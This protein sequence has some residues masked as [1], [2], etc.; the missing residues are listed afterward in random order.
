MRATCGTGVGAVYRAIFDA[1][2]F[3][4]QIDLQNFREA[5]ESL[6]QGEAQ[7]IKD[8]VD[9]VKG[10]VDS[11]RYAAMGQGR[12]YKMRDGKGGPIGGPFSSTM[13]RVA[14]SC[15]E[16]ESTQML[17]NSSCQVL[18]YGDDIFFQGNYCLECAKAIV[19]A[20]YSHPFELERDST[21]VDE[22]GSSA[23]SPCV[24]VAWM[25][26]NTVEKADGGIEVK[27]AKRLDQRYRVPIYN[28]ADLQYA[29]SIFLA[30]LAR[31][32]T[33][34]DVERLREDFAM[35]GF[36]KGVLEN[37]YH[38]SRFKHSGAMM[39]PPHHAE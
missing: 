12:V 17:R 6:K 39:D 18:R 22:A 13:S 9:L 31:H 15:C 34:E 8:G 7:Q 25:D 21:S 37:F 27:Q 26:Y 2:S 24:E 14:L 28:R 5:C 32:H 1:V 23:V 4:E 20:A 36:P 30:K 38:S 19:D 11:Y 35:N 3:F 10:F 29:R 16:N 33:P